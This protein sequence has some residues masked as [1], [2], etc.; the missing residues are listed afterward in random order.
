[1]RILLEK[2]RGPG[3]STG[4]GYWG[5]EFVRGSM[6]WRSVYIDDTGCEEGF[7]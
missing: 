3:S 6:K 1:M 7:V 4:E 5:C 2:L